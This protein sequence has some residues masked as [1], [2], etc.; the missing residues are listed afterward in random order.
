MFPDNQRDYNTNK[1]KAGNFSSVFGGKT[2]FQQ[3]KF[4]MPKS[5]TSLTGDAIWDSLSKQPLSFTF[6]SSMNFA[7]EPNITAPD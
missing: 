2:N 4:V 7:P 6:A 5:P 1:R 3:P